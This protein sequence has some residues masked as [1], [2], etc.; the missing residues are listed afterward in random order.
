MFWSTP[1]ALRNQ[2]VAGAK[3]ESTGTDGDLIYV[4]GDKTE[5]YPNRDDIYNV[6]LASSMI[7]MQ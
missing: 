3:R 6:L 1:K 5:R 4:F 7:K 2:I